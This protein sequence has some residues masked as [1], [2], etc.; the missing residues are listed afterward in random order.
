MEKRLSELIPGQE[1]VVASVLPTPIAAKL[2]EM[3]VYQGKELRVLY[4]APL[5]DPIAV[6]V[7]GYTLSL[8]KEEARNIVVHC[9]PSHL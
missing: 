1:A 8:R 2:I 3:G 7:D 4:R 5:G 9:T 6:D